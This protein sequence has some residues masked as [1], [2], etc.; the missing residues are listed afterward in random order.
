ME[1]AYTNTAHEVVPSVALNG[2]ELQTL[3]CLLSK[4]ITT[5]TPMSSGPSDRIDLVARAER[6]YAFR[7]MR[8]RLT[9][10][11]F[12][13]GLFADPAWDMMLDL[14]IQTSRGLAVT[15]TSACY[16]AIAP[17]TTA[18]RYLADLEKR[19]TIERFNNPID[20]RSICV[21]MTE[22]GMELMDNICAQ[23][24]DNEPAPLTSLIFQPPA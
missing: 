7:R 16:G 19:D 24:A 8:E 15:V 20:K 2:S 3:A 23:L 14:Y 6:H 12:G 17:P 11:V 9:N 18:L 1:H 22:K 10:A 21:R 4:V 5:A 13:D